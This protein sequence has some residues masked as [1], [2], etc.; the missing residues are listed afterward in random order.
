M[1]ILVTGG[2]GYIGS[3]TVVEL[4][5]QGHVVYIVDNLSNSDITVID[6]IKKITGIKPFFYQC[7]LRDKTSLE[8]VFKENHFDAVIHFAGFKAVGES[9]I[10][11]L[12]YYNNNLISTIYLLELMDKYHVNKIVFSS[13][14]TVYGLADYEKLLEE[15]TSNPVNTYAATKSNIENMLYFAS[16]ANKDLRVAVLRYFNPIGAHKSGLIGDAPTGFPNNLLPYIGDVASGKRDKLYVFGNDYN[17]PDGT[18]VRDYIHVLD[19]AEAHIKA[20]NANLKGYNVFNI[21]TGT[22]TSVLEIIS[23]FE[24][25]TGIK[26]NYEI[27]DR[28][29][30]DVP[31]YIADPQKA[32]KFLNWK[33]QYTIEDM[34]A[35]YWNYKKNLREA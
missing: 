14:A 19:L 11:P 32:N 28:R 24:K 18:G 31:V 3:H 34:C 16:I 26:I 4:I 5:N 10:N 15:N 6:K 33:A 20:L 8:N 25:A 30:G 35:D 7:D 9:M 2:T 22:G 29:P 12:S 1:N 13:S 17:T 23:A 21:G 27:T